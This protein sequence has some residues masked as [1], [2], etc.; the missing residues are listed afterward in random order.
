VEGNGCGFFEGYILEFD[1]IEYYKRFLDIWLSNQE[2]NPRFP[3][4]RVAIAFNSP[5]AFEQICLPF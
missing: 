2:S 5:A 1:R 4:D 3:R